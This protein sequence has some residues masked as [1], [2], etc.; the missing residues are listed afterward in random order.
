MHK[1]QN[2][3]ALEKARDLIETL[4]GEVERLEAEVRKERRPPEPRIVPDGMGEPFI[5]DV[6]FRP[7]GKIYRFLLLQTH[8]GWYTTGVDKHDYF[9]DW[10]ALLDWLEGP[11]VHGHSSMLR[12]IRHGAGAALPARSND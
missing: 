6:M 3:I 7:G 2:E 1:T 8:K 12:L 4:S 10:S 11:D 5:V 9:K